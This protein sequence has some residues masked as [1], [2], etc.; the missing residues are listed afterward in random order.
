MYLVD[1]GVDLEVR[2]NH[3]LTAMD[4]VQMHVGHFPDLMSEG[5]NTLSML[6]LD[7]DDMKAR[8]RVRAFLTSGSSFG[9]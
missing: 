9:F 4:H 2:D 5:F 3:G 8:N 6:L 1:R 7:S